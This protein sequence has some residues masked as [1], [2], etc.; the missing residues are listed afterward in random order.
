MKAVYLFT[1]R[2]LDFQPRSYFTSQGIHD[3]CQKGA[4]PVI[5]RTPSV[6]TDGHSDCILPQRSIELN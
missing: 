4:N 1:R 3:L 5:S 6:V 2:F